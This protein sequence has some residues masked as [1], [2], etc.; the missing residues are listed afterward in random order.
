MAYCEERGLKGIADD[1]TGGGGIRE[2]VG[3]GIR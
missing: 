2:G 3:G 1:D